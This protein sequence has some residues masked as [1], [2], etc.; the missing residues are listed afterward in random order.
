MLCYLCS[1][2]YFSSYPH[3]SKFIYT[4]T[5][6]CVHAT[7]VA[8]LLQLVYSKMWTN[9]CLQIIQRCK[10]TLA[11][12]HM[13]C[14]EHW[15][16]QSCRNRC[17]LCHFRFNAIETL[18]YRWSESLRIWMSHPRNRRYVQSDILVLGLLTFVTIGL[19]AVCL[20]GMRYF[21]IEGKKIGVSR[22]WTQG[23]IIFFLTIVVVGYFTTAYLLVK[24]QLTPWY[25]WWKNTVN[26]RLVIEPQLNNKIHCFN[27]I[28]DHQNEETIMKIHA[29]DKN[30]QI[31]NL[32]EF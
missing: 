29:D 21:I 22:V 7:F 16:N 6:V 17:E 32:T 2:G 31:I 8:L 13:S 27:S 23:A 24:E 10:G 9:V 28:S 12:V 3:I 19:V 15:L 26:V 11:Y 5:H 30:I 1:L 4:R 20:L 14:L 18:R 25:R